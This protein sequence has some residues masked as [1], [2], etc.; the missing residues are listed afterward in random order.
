MK[1]KAS[2]YEDEVLKEVNEDI[3]SASTIRDDINSVAETNKQIQLLLNDILKVYAAQVSLDA[4]DSLAKYNA[5]YT[6]EG[7][8]GAGNG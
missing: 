4:M 8:E 1:N 6:G 3:S 2:N 5:K 7:N